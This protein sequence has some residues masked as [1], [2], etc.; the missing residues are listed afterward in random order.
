[1][2]RLHL[3]LA[4]VRALLIQGS[5]PGFYIT[6]GASGACALALV[7]YLFLTSVGSPQV[8]AS[9]A[10]DIQV[11]GVVDPT[12]ARATPEVAPLPLFVQTE[13]QTNPLFAPTETPTLTPTPTP[14]PTLTPT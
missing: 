12:T 7:V 3:L 6:L 8:D 11:V 10:E 13:P 4:P 14:T 1:M 2:S 9:V 5:V